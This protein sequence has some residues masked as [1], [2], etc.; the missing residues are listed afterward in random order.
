MCSVYLI[1]IFLCQLLFWLQS[2]YTS[3]LCNA[4]GIFHIFASEKFFGYVRHKFWSSLISHCRKNP[5]IIQ[6]EVKKE[7]NVVIPRWLRMAQIA[8]SDCD[9]IQFSSRKQIHLYFCNF[10]YIANLKHKYI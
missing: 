3:F 5:I 8:T 1:D 4:Y 9:F 7:E 6:F 10:A 2:I